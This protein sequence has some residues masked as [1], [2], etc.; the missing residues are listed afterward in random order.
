MKLKNYLNPYWITS[1]LLLSLVS[2][3]SAIQLTG[4][5]EWFN[6]VKMRV[7]ADG[8]IKKVH[9]KIGQ[10]VKKGDLLLS[11]DQRE[12]NAKLLQAKASLAR[13]KVNLADADDELKRSLEL[14]DRGLIADE[15]LKDSKMKYAATNAEHE[16]AKASLVVA[17]VALERNVLRAPMNGIIITRNAYDGGVV[18]KTLQKTPLIAIAPNGKMLARVLVTS[19]VLR[20]YPLG[21]KAQIN[22]YGKNYNGFIYSQGVEAVRIEPRGAVYNLDILFSHSPQELMRPSDKV[23]VTLP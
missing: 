10:H 23:I 9:V 17:K 6:K 18:Y 19:R 14:Y 20:K 4:H 5:L 3:A 12:A 13:N 1:L 15:E 11:M 22:I 8:V 2:N 7:L 16:S 21:K